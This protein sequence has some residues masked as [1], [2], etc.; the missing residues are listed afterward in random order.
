MLNLAKILKQ[1]FSNSL[2]LLWQGILP[3]SRGD[4][5]LCEEGI[6]YRSRVSNMATKPR[7]A[8]FPWRASSC[9]SV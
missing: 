4:D 2:G 1:Q 9:F 3:P 5:I 8:V 6:H 7:A